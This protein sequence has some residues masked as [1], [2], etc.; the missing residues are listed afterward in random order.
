[1]K[2]QSTH[3]T[4]EDKQEGPKQLPMTIHFLLSDASPFLQAM[5]LTFGEDTTSLPSILNEAFLMMKVQT[6]SQRRYVLRWPCHRSSIRQ[7]TS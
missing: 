4:E 1:M 7:I 6:S 3:N 2:R 5:I